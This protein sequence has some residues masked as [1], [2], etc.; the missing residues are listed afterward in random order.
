MKK[1]RGVGAGH[2]ITEGAFY[3]MLQDGP[4]CARDSQKQWR[5]SKLSDLQEGTA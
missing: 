2:I 5:M 4:L 3:L 1:P